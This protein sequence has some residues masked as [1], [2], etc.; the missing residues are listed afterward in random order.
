M[1]SRQT[2]TN[3]LYQQC[4]ASYRETGIQAP[5]RTMKQEGLV[6]NDTTAQFKPQKD[7][8]NESK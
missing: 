1:G 5:D 7:A 3:T 6:S 8:C 4:A 2:P